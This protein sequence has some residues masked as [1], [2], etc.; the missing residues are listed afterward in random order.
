MQIAVHMGM[1]S[2]KGL[3]GI[4]SFSLIHAHAGPMIGVAIRPTGKV[5][6]IRSHENATGMSCVP[7]WMKPNTS[8]TKQSEPQIDAVVFPKGVRG[9][10]GACEVFE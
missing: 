9:I 7:L 4:S 6:K 2:K 1:R 5:M 3:Y 10:I 8:N